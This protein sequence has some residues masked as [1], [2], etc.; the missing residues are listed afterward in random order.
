MT[1]DKAIELGI[2]AEFSLRSHKFIDHADAIELLIEAGKRV[3]EHRVTPVCRPD[4]PLPG[5]TEK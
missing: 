2:E 4:I 3:R 5:E 1:I